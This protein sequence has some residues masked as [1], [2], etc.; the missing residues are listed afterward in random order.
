[1]RNRARRH[2]QGP[3]RRLGAVQRG[4]L[5]L[6]G[7]PLPALQ[8]RIRAGGQVAGADG[9][10]PRRVRLPVQAGAAGRGNLYIA[11]A[12]RAGRL[13]AGQGAG[14]RRQRRRAGQ[15]AVLLKHACGH[16]HRAVSQQAAVVTQGLLRR[17]VRIAL[18][19]QRAPLRQGSGA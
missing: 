11:L 1:M 8:V 10:R 7:E 17:D 13:T 16:V 15:G 5:R 19:A 14:L 4:V 3:F 9:D 12:G 18:R 6:Q 2:R